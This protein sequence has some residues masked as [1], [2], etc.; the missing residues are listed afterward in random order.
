[1]LSDCSAAEITSLMSYTVLMG[2]AIFLWIIFIGWLMWISKSDKEVFLFY[3]WSAM[4]ITGLLGI[5]YEAIFG[6]IT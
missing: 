5:V 6:V 1:M 3:T 4:F 2:A